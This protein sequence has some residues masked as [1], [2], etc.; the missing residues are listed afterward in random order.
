ME[1]YIYSPTQPFESNRVR[2]AW[3]AEQKSDYF[4]QQISQYKRTLGIA[5]GCEYVSSITNSVARKSLGTNEAGKLILDGMKIGEHIANGLGYGMA[6]AD[7]LQL[8]QEMY[9]RFILR[10]NYTP[11]ELQQIAE[12]DKMIEECRE[13]SNKNFLL[14]TIMA[15]GLFGVCQ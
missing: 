1:A 5:D 6:R 2:N 9:I 12:M 15:T 11:S 3:G 10:G 8:R 4:N 14:G 7:L 13:R